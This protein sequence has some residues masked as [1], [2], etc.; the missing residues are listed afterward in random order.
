MNLPPTSRRRSFWRTRVSPELPR[1]YRPVLE[2]LGNRCLLS[3]GFSQVNLASDVPGLARITD[4]NLENPW[5]IAFSPTGPFWFADN[6][7]GV[8]DIL[9]GSGQ[10]VPL[11]VTVPSALPSGSTPTGT[12]FNAGA[13]FAISEKGVSAPSRFLFATA[14]GTISGWSAVVDP[15]RALLAVDHSSSGAVYLGLALATDSAGK[16]SLY[17]AD[18]GRGTVDVFDQGFRPVVRPGAFQ[19][20][21]LPDGF[22]P[23][24]IQKIDNLLFVTYALRDEDG[25]DDVAGPGNGVID[26]YDP[27]GSLVRRFASGGPLNSPWGLAQ[28]PADFGPFAGALL[29]GNNGDGL[30]NA[31]AP[32]SGNF[33]GELGDENGTPIT[34]PNL[35]ALTFGNG[36]AGGDSDTLFFS[37]GVGYDEHGLFGAVQGPE[38][39][40]ADTAGL[41]AFDPNAPGEPG[42]YPL[43]PRG[44]PG[45]RAGDEDRPFPMTD[46]LPLKESSLALVPTL[47]A[48]LE[49]NTGAAGTVPGA[50]VVGGSFSGSVLTPGLVSDTTLLIPVDGNSQPVRG[51]PNSAVALNTFLDWDPSA[52]VPTRKVGVQEPDAPRGPIGFLSSPSS[53][54]EGEAQGFLSETDGEQLETTGSEA[55][56]LGARPP[57]GRADEILGAVPPESRAELT[58]ECPAGSQSVSTKKGGW[59]NLMNLLLVVTLPMIWTYR[60]RH[61]VKS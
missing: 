40:G 44:G 5:G 58:E 17:A 20:P 52:T 59:M 33:L 2:Y 46:L 1:R 19:D 49:P 12:V 25:H 15:S 50:P 61:K 9:D 3:G 30:I 35:W 26:V 29:V 41:G 6:G 14:D 11:V 32:G 56:G 10:P 42:D 45:F 8:S 21:N 22:A 47:S 36:H 60:G 27:G 51:D 37:A 31:F 34:I 18:F 53:D 43:P 16:S 4:P 54:R 24:N 23:F 55:Q 57:S 28:A 39:R 7:S 38:R 48:T 13:G